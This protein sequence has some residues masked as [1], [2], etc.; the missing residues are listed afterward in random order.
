MKPP[1][2]ELWRDIA[3]DAAPGGLE[4][5]TLKAA[6][7]AVRRRKFIRRANAWAASVI[8]LAVIGQLLFHSRTLKEAGRNRVTQTVAGVRSPSVAAS[9]MVAAGPQSIRS[10]MPAAPVAEGTADVGPAYSTIND[11]ELLALL[12]GCP[13]AL[14][15]DGQGSEE[16][17]FVHPA[18]AE[19]FFGR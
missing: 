1:I 7:G 12:D 3:R 17:V 2:N 6:L 10:T 5:Q 9:P 11:R 16:L 4:A 8:A 13:A 19:R 15:R 18:D 14:V